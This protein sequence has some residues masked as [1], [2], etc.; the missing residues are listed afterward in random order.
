MNDGIDPLDGQNKT[1]A[2][3]PR[4]MGEI[5]SFEEFYDGYKELL[6][7]YMDLSADAQYS[8]Y[9]IMN[10]QVKF[11]FTSILMDDC[12]ERGKALLDGGVRYLG[13]TCETYGNINTSDSLYAVKKLVFDDKNL[14]LNSFAT[15]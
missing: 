6:D 14:L 2:V 11:L 10:E 1:G 8:S 9:E 7:Y 3:V 5:K 15:L 4:K 13:G 12:I